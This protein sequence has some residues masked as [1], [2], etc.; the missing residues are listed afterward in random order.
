MRTKFLTLRTHKFSL[1]INHLREQLAQCAWSAALQ[2][3][4]VRFIGDT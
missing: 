4:Q 1:S 3:F 2:P